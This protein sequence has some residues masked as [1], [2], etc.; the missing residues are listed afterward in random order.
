MLVKYNTKFKILHFQFRT[1]SKTHQD[2]HFVGLRYERGRKEKGERGKVSYV[3]W[4]KE[5]PGKGTKQ[6]LFWLCFLKRVKLGQ[7][8]HSCTY[9]YTHK[10]PRNSYTQKLTQVQTQPVKREAVSLGWNKNYLMFLNPI[11]CS[12]N[13]S[14]T[15]VQ[16]KSTEKK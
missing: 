5:T 13:Y 12:P 2:F 11:M 7:H 4:V 9:H 16:K 8:A 10:H 1:V 6:Q 14:I 3:Q 15:N